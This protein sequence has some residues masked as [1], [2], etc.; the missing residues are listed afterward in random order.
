MQSRCVPHFRRYL[1]RLA[2]ATI[3]TALL[4]Q[5]CLPTFA[6]T[7]ARCFICSGLNCLLDL[8][9]SSSS[10]TP[11]LYY[12]VIYSLVLLLRVPSTVPPTGIGQTLSSVTAVPSTSRGSDTT[13]LT[14]TRPLRLIMDAPQCYTCMDL[15]FFGHLHKLERPDGE[16]N[17]SNKSAWNVSDTVQ[18]FGLSATSCPCCALILKAIYVVERKAASDVLDQSA[19]IGIYMSDKDPLAISYSLGEDTRIEVYSTGGL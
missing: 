3:A 7:N 14:P 11:L 17:A 2:D 5:C 4:T 12:F 13:S 19:Y 16:Y 18:R 15:R 10:F 1:R 6:A 9:L 8:G